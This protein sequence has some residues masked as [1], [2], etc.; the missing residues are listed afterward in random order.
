MGK[1]NVKGYELDSFD[2]KNASPRRAVQFK[3]SIIEALKQI[4]VK[5]DFVEI[6]IELIVTK[7]AKASVTW[8]SKTH[9]M[10]YS[11]NSQ[12]T[13]IAN[14]YLVLQLLELEV[15]RVVSGE[16]TMQEFTIEFSED[17]DIEDERKEARDFLGLEHNVNDLEVINK[18]YKELAKE[19][20]PDMPNGSTDKFKQLNRAHKILKRELQ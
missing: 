14:L 4:G 13:F 20:H 6:P 19:F 8:Y 3:N 10:Y 12:K 16:K 11:N 1:I 18:K 15:G 2:A 7:K 5:K 17:N 9:R